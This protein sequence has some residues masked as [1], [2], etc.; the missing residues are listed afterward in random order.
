[1]K[2]YKL[3]GAIR[4][5]KALAKSIIMLMA[6]MDNTP[7]RFNADTVSD[8]IRDLVTNGDFDEELSMEIVHQMD[9]I[10]YE[11][12]IDHKISELDAAIQ[13]AQDKKNEIL[14]KLKK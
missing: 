9:S 12:L 7:R 11:H 4:K 3:S 5:E 14:K 2:N 10:E 8:E 13:D 1:M 6:V